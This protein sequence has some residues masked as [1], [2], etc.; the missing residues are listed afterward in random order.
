MQ[1]ADTTAPLQIEG[2]HIRVTG[3]FLRLARIRSEGW[4]F[5]EDPERFLAAL[6]TSCSKADLFSFTRRITD[7]EPLGYHSE[8]NPIAVLTIE[9]YEKW[10]KSQINDK[11]RNMVRKADKKGVNIRLTEFND[12][13]VRGIQAIHDESPVRQGKLFEHY[14]KD[15]E[16]VKREHGT[17][18]DRSVFIGAYYGEELIGFIKVVHDGSSAGIMQILS[19]LCHRD[20]APT[21]ALMAKAVEVCT[22]RQIRHLIY[23]VWG[24]S[25]L[26]D[27]KAANAF[28]C[29][30]TPRYF[31]ALTLKG[32][33]AL[34]L[35]LHRRL[36]DL[37]P[38]RLTRMA[39]DLRRRVRLLKPLKLVEADR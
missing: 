7:V 20:K 34:K 22:E 17:F 27:F 39:A 15:F 2:K 29:H 10:W 13:L 1:P 28:E 18:L 35:G 30:Q 6:R 23:G 9:T 38:P 3:R 36:V 11:T 8:P 37:L 12:D 25:G 32:K 4:V 31:V 26:S 14:G 33:L 21:N 5:I 19:K 16:T 24:R